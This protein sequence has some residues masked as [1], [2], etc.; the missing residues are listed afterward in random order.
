M[1][2]LKYKT[3]E[4]LHY[5]QQECRKLIKSLGSQKAGQEERLKWINHYIFEKTPQEL[6]MKEIEARLG[7]KVIIK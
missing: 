6:T 1:S 3:V 7:H 2:D 4:Q 5:A